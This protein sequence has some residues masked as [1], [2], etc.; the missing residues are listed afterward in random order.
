MTQRINGYEK[1][2][3][4]KHIAEQQ[5]IVANIASIKPTYIDGVRVPAVVTKD[6]TQ[7]YAGSDWDTAWQIVRAHNHSLQDGNPTA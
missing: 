5:Q 6:G 3:S 4:K 7:L 2:V 1:R